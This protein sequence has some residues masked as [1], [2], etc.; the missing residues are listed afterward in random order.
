MEQ[1]PGREGYYELYTMPAAKQISV[2]AATAAVL[3]K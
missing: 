1:T 2:H 3:H